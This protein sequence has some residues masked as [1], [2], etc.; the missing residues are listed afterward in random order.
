MWYASDVLDMGVLI[1]WRMA[2]WVSGL[3]GDVCDCIV[4]FLVVVPSSIWVRETGEIREQDRALQ[5]RTV[6][7]SIYKP[8]TAGNHSQLFEGSECDRNSNFCQLKIASY[9]KH[10]FLS[11]FEKT[12]GE[13]VAMGECD[14]VDVLRVLLSLYF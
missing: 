5:M 3:C 9:E 13:C 6:Q 11:G 4:D 2:P 12:T 7:A 1:M 10:V 8:L 14:G